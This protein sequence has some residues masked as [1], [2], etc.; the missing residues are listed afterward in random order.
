V[1]GWAQHVDEI[2]PEEAA[3]IAAMW[4]DRHQAWTA[5][6]RRSR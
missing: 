3:E 4:W 2:E 6:R 5:A 1:G